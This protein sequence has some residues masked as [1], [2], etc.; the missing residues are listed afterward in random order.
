M[1]SVYR[2]G[3]Y[4]LFSLI[5]TGM[6]SKIRAKLSNELADKNKGDQDWGCRWGFPFSLRATQFPPPNSVISDLSGCHDSGIYSSNVVRE[7]RL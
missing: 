1:D 2:P 4:S 3:R 5:N 6:R 7:C